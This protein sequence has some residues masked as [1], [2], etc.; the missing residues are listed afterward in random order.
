MVLAAGNALENSLVL[1]LKK[2]GNK[3]TKQNT[4]LSMI[5]GTASAEPEADM[6]TNAAACPTLG[7]LSWNENV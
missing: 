5:T 1:R 6:V 7:F 3:K 4:N 2:V